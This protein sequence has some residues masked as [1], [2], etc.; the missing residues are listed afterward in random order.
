MNNEKVH[1]S[2]SRGG[3][4]TLSPLL[5]FLGV[6][7]FLMTRLHADSGVH[8]PITVAFLAAACYAVAITRGMTLEER[9]RQ[10]SAGAADKNILLMIWI[11][12]LAGAFAQSAKEL[13]AIDA[14]VNLTLL[15]LP[16]NLLPAGIFIAACFISLSI[17]T[18]VGTIV[19]LTPVAVGLADRT[20]M[21]L[22]FMVGV[23]VGGSFFGDNLSFISDTTIAATKTQACDM[24]DKFK[25][26]F[27]IVVPAAI[28]VLGI[29]VVKGFAITGS[30]PTDA[31][32]WVKV[33]PYI[34]VL[35]TALAGMNVMAVL[36]IGIAAVGAIGLVT[37]TWDMFHWFGSMGTGI[38]GMGELII[39]TLLAGGILELI[40]E[41]GGID[42]IIRKFT[43]RI[44]G[45]RGAELSIAA[46]VSLANL[47]TANNTIA[48]ITTGPIAKRIAREYHLDPRKSASILD[49]FSCFIQGILPY[50]AQMLMAAGLAGISPI[51]VIGNLYY[52]FT[53]G[54]CALLAILLRYPK[55][56]S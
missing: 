13:G 50:G 32:D 21:A 52:P 55:K 37:G 30:A 8:L 26:N 15:L 45:K 27:Q 40:R 7:L 1:K 48:I 18:S 19:A 41:G 33:I 10:F 16:D 43:R 28:V 20:G 47:C 5:V 12:V 51:S 36:L 4:W 53:M 17:G 24:R 35:A 54:L 23:V 44:S 11:F 6:Y 34:I 14:T 56:Y 9:V 39:V 3:W 31:I 42:F 2:R 38:T 22:P 46:L 29:Y 49:T 25:V